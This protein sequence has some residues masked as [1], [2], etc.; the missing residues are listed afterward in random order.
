[1]LMFETM[2]SWVGVAIFRDDE[3]LMQLRDQDRS[4]R[5]AGLWVLPGGAVEDGEELED[6]AR[7][8]FVEET[9]ILPYSL[10]FGLSFITLEPGCTEPTRFEYFFATHRNGD[11]YL[12]FEG[13]EMSFRFVGDVNALDS[14][15]YLPRVVRELHRLHQ[16]SR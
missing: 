7:R 12:C 15:D 13:Q 10:H 16:A 3:V 1:M 2:R 5:D 11:E 6:A 14:P 4:I 9:G 8:E